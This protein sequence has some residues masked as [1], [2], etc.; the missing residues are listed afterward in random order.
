M[1]RKPRRS[2]SHL[3]HDEDFFAQPIQIRPPMALDE[4]FRAIGGHR[5]EILTQLT[6]E[7][8]LNM[9]DIVHRLH[10]RH[11]SGAS[12]DLGNLCRA[13]LLE[14]AK[15]GST[16]WFRLRQ[17][18]QF[19]SFENLGRVQ[20]GYWLPNGDG[21]WVHREEFSR[22]PQPVPI[23]MTFLDPG[24][25]VGQARASP[26]QSPSSIAVNRSQWPRFPKP[27]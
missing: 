16:H 21:M 11:Q 4:L 10:L 24:L 22:C 12:R 15:D 1:S 8:P 26:V 20:F 3:F 6:L 18:H 14:W 17:Q 23:P 19:L 27:V 7:H 25:S 5:Y 13:G 9:G 2:A